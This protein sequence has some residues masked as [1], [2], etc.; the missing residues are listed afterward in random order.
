MNWANY[1]LQVNFYLI[2][3]F[4]FYWLLLRK[5]TFYSANRYFLLANSLLAVLIPFWNIGLIESWFVTEQVSS[6][7]AVVP[8]EEFTVTPLMEKPTWSWN[9]L[10]ASIY[11]LGFGFGLLR[12]SLSLFRLQQLL[13]IKNL[14]GQAFSIFGKV[15]IDKKLDDYRTIRLHE[16][17]HSRQFH[18]IDVFWMELLGVICWFN[19]AVLWMRKEI[20]VIHEFIADEIA[21]RHLGSAQKYVQVLVSSHFN[22]DSNVLINNF[23][24]NSILKTRIMK[25][26]QQKSKRN[27]AWK[28][29]F[30]TPLFLSMLIFSAASNGQNTLKPEREFE[31]SKNEIFTLV[32]NQPEFPGGTS[33]LYEYIRENMKYPETAQSA[34]IEGRVFVKFIV[35]KEGNTQSPEIIKGLG[36]GCDQEVIRIIESMPKWKPGYQNDKPVNVYFTMPFFF[37]LGKNESAQSSKN[38]LFD[39]TPNSENPPY[40][41]VNGKAASA[42]EIKSLN[43]DDIST[44]NVLKGEAAIKAYGDK[45]KNGV[46]E[47][48]MK[49]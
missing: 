3:G 27:K 42:S 34:N 39:L 43:K 2:L 29:F 4:G 48:I 12:F 6:A 44:I 49:N 36:F 46:L 15:F 20:K 25:L 5:E 38:K 47:I 33:A 8:L 18:S 22:A 14:R 26:A 35:D 11:F 45:G 16:E 32:E 13:R 7:I 10:G 9:L 41:L 30:A 31:R 1:L 37:E 40:I 19:P 23:Y 28:Y 24:N 17:V 21:A